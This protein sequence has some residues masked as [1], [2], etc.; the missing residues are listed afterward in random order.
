VDI[1]TRPRNSLVKQYQKLFE[2]DDVRLKFTKPAPQAIAEKPSSARAGA[3]ASGPSSR[4]H[5]RHHVRGAIQEGGQGGRRIDDG[6]HNGTVPVMVYM[7][8][9]EPA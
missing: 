1:L 4:T 6:L 9:A 5:A 2:M 8:E 3:R 7:D